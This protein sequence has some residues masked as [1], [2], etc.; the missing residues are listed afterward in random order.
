V[1]AGLGTRPAGHRA[2]HRAGGRRDVPSRAQRARAWLRTLPLAGGSTP[3]RLRRAA[4]VL[5]LGC[6]AAAA[7][8]L[9]SGIGRSDAVNDGDTRIA[10]L[11]TDAAAIYQALADA[12]ATATSGYV[13]AGREPADVRAR[14]DTDI[15]RASER[16]VHA[17]GLIP[18]GDPAAAS[19]TTLT[20]QLPVYTSLV[21]TA[22]TYNR[23]G[24]PLGQSYLTRASKLMQNTMLPAV[25][26]LREMGTQR[27]DGAYRQ[28][29]ALPVAVLV[30]GVGLLIAVVDLSIGEQRRTNRVLN[31][32]LVGTAVAV[33][34]ALVWWL[35]ATLL[36]GAALAAADRHT[37]AV[38]ALDDARTAALQARSN[39]SLVLVARG[40]GTGDTT[41]Q[42]LIERVI[43]P[44]GQGGLLADA[45][46]NGATVS[47]VRAAAQ[48]WK[49][50]HEDVR[51]LDGKGQFGEAVQSVI[52]SDPRGSNVRFATLDNELAKAIETERASL[53]ADIARAGGAQGLLAVGPAVLFLLGG[54]AAAIGI[55][56]RV[57]EYR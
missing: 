49:L 48:A 22:R 28:G 4:V 53:D 15:Q 19:V 27:L 39:E 30:L 50:A 32:G 18:D 2:D 26:E 36:T 12:D 33:L 11:T 54:V 43:G 44:D 52:G 37:D 1:T 9:G 7:V 55:G 29:T 6:L 20:T 3:A 31:P 5:V 24:L 25:A 34:A 38:T 10:E 35:L 45:E 16:L 47:S 13:A 14:Y 41:Y 8:S 46:A 17:A 57:G 21:E 40:G 51:D 42:M 23:Q 56:R